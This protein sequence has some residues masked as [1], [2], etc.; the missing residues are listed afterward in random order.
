MV[1]CKFADVGNLGFELVQIIDGSGERIY[2]AFT[3]WCEAMRDKGWLQRHVR[4]AQA[5]ATRDEAEGSP[6]QQAQQAS[7]GHDGS[8]SAEPSTHADEQMKAG[9]AGHE[10]Q[11]QEPGEKEEEE[12]ESG[13]EEEREGAQEM[14][15]PLLQAALQGQEAYTAGIDEGGPAVAQQAEDEDGLV[16]YHE[17]LAELEPS[18]ADEVRPAAAAL[19]TERA[20]A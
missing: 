5:D 10:Q 1:G 15:E 13:E 19:S 7:A 16:W 17:Q 20:H 2:P 6:R 9:H 11:E 12:R 18:R 4:V 8:G 14:E 3:Q